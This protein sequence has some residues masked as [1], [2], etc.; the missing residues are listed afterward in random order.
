MPELQK[1][2]EAHAEALDIR[3]RLHGKHH[4][5]TAESL[6]NLA[7]VY[8]HSGDRASARPLF[9][10]AAAVYGAL[11]GPE[12]AETRDAAAKAARCAAV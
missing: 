12:H 10:R 9:E 5:E 1:A 2:A 4:L 11:R 7:A 3:L 8:A 6:Y